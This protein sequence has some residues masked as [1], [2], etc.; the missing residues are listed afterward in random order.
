MATSQPSPAQ[1]LAMPRPRP[2][3]APV[4][5]TTGLALMDLALRKFSCALRL[6]RDAAGSLYK[7]SGQPRQLGPVVIAQNL[8]GDERRT[9]AERG[10]T[11]L[12]ETGQGVQVHAAGRHDAQM[13]QRRAQ[14]FDVAVTEAIG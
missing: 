12:Q 8:G 2:R 4:T 7:F 9:D 5:R 1:L 13:R 6:S 3:L 11:R 14:G 10:A